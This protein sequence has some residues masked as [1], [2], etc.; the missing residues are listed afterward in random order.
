M[1]ALDLRIQPLAPLGIDLSGAKGMTTVR[2]KHNKLSNNDK[3]C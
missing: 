3:E 1:G 2:T